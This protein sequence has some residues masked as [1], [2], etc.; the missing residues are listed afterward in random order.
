MTDQG[1]DVGECLI[2]ERASSAIAL[3][4]HDVSTWVAL[5]LA[6]LRKKQYA[7]TL[8]PHTEVPQFRY[9]RNFDHRNHIRHYLGTFIGLVVHECM[10]WS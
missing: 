3:Y 7:I 4:T 2:V 8:I 6:G 1:S 9:R 5:C 10:W